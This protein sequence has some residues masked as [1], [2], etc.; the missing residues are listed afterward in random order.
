MQYYK[1]W[2]LH[3]LFSKQLS[4]H[5][6]SGQSIYKATTPYRYQPS[7]KLSCMCMVSHM[8]SSKPCREWPGTEGKISV[9]L[10]HTS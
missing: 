7:N 3:H 4:I 1:F 8:Q 2:L 9:T 5:P 6:L 10:S